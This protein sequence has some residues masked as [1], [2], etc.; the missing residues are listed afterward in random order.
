MSIADLKLTSYDAEAAQQQFPVVDALY[1]EVF[2]E[3]PHN[4][5]PEEFRL[6]AT[7]WWPK[8][9]AQPEFQLVIAT[10]D[11]EPVGCTYGHRLAADTT[12]W[13]GAVEP[14]PVEIT[15]EH[16]GRTAAIIEM[17]VQAPFRRRGVAAAMHRAFCE[18]RTEERVTLTVRP[19]NHPAHRGYEKWGYRQVGQIRP[20]RRAPVYDAMILDL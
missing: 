2:A 20:A 9:S 4:E 10:V 16:E 19:D 3:P 7:R 15:E 11:G 5:G 14:L 17:M 18:G 8:Q 1:Q 12:W 6:F 13:K